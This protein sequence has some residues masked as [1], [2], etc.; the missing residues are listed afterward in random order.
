[1]CYLR[2][3]H[4]LLSEDINPKTGTEDINTLTMRTHSLQ[5]VSNDVLEQ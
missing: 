5:E 3:S 1:L 2:E 4:E